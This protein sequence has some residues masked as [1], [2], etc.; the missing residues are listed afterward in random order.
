[1][2]LLLRSSCLCAGVGLALPSKRNIKYN[3]TNN[4][5]SNSSFIYENKKEYTH[6][7]FSSPTISITIA[8]PAWGSRSTPPAGRGPP[9]EFHMI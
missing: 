3:E 2:C 4:N 9:E 7:S 1:M 5:N 6:V 8:A